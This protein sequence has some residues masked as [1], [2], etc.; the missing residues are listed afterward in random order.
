MI[1]TCDHCEK[2]YKIDPDKIKGPSARFK[3][4]ACGNIVT[5]TKPEEAPE[6]LP[7]TGTSTKKPV[8]KRPVK[9]VTGDTTAGV[10]TSI[11][12]KITL[13][14]VL[15]VLVSLGIVGVIA[16]KTSREALTKQAENHLR[17]IST[18]KAKEYN[19]LFGRI[20]EEI[21]SLANYSSILYESD[22]I[23]TENDFNLVLI[24]NENGPSKGVDF[25]AR[26]AKVQKKYMQ[27]QRMGQIFTIFV[28]SNPYLL[29]GHVTSES[30]DGSTIMAVNDKV[31]YEA[32]LG[33]DT[34]HP[35]IRPWYK[36]VKK[37]QKTIWTAP[38]IDASTIVTCATPV[39]G[40]D[41]NFIGVAAFDVALTTIEQDIL[42]LDIGYNSY[43]FLI[44]KEGKALVRPGMKKGDLKQ[45]S[46]YTADNLL[47]TGNPEFT[48][49]TRKMIQ[50][51]NGIDTY[52]DPDKGET[53][54]A[55]SPIK[56]I[57]A[58]M[59]IAVLKKAVLQPAITAQMYINVACLIVLVISIIIGIL[60]GNGITKPINKLTMMTNLISQ[61]KMDLDVIEENRKDEIGILTQSFN[62]LVISLKLAMSR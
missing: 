22:D 10:T 26:K 11:I 46:S 20:N 8:G 17:Q 6:P 34:Y 30:F 61:G 18:Q 12:T 23:K 50:G 48:K 53:Y 19:Q 49:I 62:R 57:N 43:A 58:S 27:F 47:K 42:K 9:E 25:D 28:K 60:I 16:V 31:T 21:E 39:F 59:G 15:L 41:K 13:I 7:V 52:N 54:I 1:T 4:K 24:F 44:D 29:A 40:S 37:S 51:A 45:D 56:A 33:L 14:I 3:C 32:F 2:K 36:N 38:Y 35:N 5:I 55:F